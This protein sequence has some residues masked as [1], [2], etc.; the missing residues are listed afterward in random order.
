[1]RALRS[2]M[3]AGVLAV[4]LAGCATVTEAGYYWGDYSTSLYRLTK[5]PSKD[6]LAAHVTTLEKMIEEADRRG[7]RVPP[8]IHA[9][10]G[11]LKGKQGDQA[12]RD[13]HFVLEI[14]LYPE[15][16]VFAEKLIATPPKKVEK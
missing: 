3:L 10:L 12:A 8:G 4:L 13:R 1:M 15:A 2:T 5:D 11:Y 6:T 7:L 16:R 14:R 9:E